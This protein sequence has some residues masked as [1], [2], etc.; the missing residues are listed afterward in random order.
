L[1]SF[2]DLR[3]QVERLRRE[4]WLRIVA[5]ERPGRVPGRRPRD[6]AKEDLLIRLDRLR[7]ERLEEERGIRL[8][9][10]TDPPE[11]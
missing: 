11:P 9:R 3:E 1:I 7:L 8:R 6:G 10:G 5:G 4:H 2:D